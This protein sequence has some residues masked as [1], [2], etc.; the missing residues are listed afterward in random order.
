MTDLFDLFLICYMYKTTGSIENHNKW[1]KGMEL[2]K[3]AIWIQMK[4][5][6]IITMDYYKLYKCYCISQHMATHEYCLFCYY[7]LITF[8]N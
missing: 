3:S 1:K 7:H 4:Q 8:Y 5:R 2:S 6:Q